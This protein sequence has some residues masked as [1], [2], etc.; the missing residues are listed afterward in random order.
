MLLCL[1]KQNPDC[2]TLFKRLLQHSSNLWKCNILPPLFW[3]KRKRNDKIYYKRIEQLLRKS[4]S[5][6]I[7]YSVDFYSKLISKKKNQILLNKIFCSKLLSY[8][9]ISCFSQTII[10]FSNKPWKSYFKL[11][12]YE[13]PK[14]SCFFC[15]S[16]QSNQRKKLVGENDKE[17]GKKKQ[18]TCFAG[19]VILPATSDEGNV[20]A[21][22]MRQHA[23][24]LQLKSVSSCRI[25]EN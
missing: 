23:W 19:S 25:L 9:W 16:Q 17:L 15:L 6:T 1:L 22:N 2:F 13:G 24:L 14:R 5:G 4:F 21:Q 11:L 7:F 18:F 20:L 8:L 12:A 10:Q 3:K